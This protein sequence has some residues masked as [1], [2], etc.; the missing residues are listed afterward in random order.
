VRLLAPELQPWLDE[1]VRLGK[2]DAL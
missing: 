2:E 1:R